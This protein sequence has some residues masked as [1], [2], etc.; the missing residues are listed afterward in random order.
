MSL[1]G[2]AKD[3]LRDVRKRS[4]EQEHRIDSAG[5]YEHWRMSDATGVSLVER[6]LAVAAMPIAA[7]WG[8]LLVVLSI[9]MGF[10]LIIF[11]VLSKLVPRR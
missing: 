4:L 1:I 7:L 11:K 5:H 6:G 8:L 9:G 3:G 10:A 2:A